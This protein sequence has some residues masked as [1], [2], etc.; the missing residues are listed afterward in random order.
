MEHLTLFQNSSQYSS[1][2]SSD[3]FI[4]PNV[5]YIIDDNENHYTPLPHDYSKDY[6]TFEAIDSGTFKFSAKTVDYSLDGGQS[7][8]S[9]ASNT[10]T[11]TVSAGS[12]ILFKSSDTT[13]SIVSSTSPFNIEGNIMS[14]LYSDDFQGKTSL[15]GVYPLRSLFKG[16]KVVSCE[17]LVLPA[18]SVGSSGYSGM[19]SG[20]TALTIA[21]ELPAMTLGDY[22]YAYMFRGCTSL[23]KAPVLPATELS[24]QN[25]YLGMF[26][27]CSNLNYIKCMAIT[28]VGTIKTQDWVSGVASSGTFVKNSAATWSETF[29]N[30]AIPRGWTVET[31]SA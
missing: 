8:V 11:P 24:I 9:L 17:N 12:K 27:S 29:A 3:R 30:N 18:V 28:G 21:P 6:L 4:K 23:T 1:F 25:T 19:F 16:S 15:S 10:N 14:I 5:S 13:T 26:M 7:W 2:V 31:A 20:C 22:C